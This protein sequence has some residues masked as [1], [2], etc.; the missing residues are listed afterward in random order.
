MSVQL[1]FPTVHGSSSQ[2]YDAELPFALHTASVVFHLALL[3]SLLL[4]SSTGLPELAH[5]SFQKLQQFSR[6]TCSLP[7]TSFIP[8]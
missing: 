7:A 8:D 6:S 1:R 4:S 2:S 5:R 3:R